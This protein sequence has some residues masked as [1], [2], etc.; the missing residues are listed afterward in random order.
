MPDDYFHT[1]IAEIVDEYDLLDELLRRPV[2][3]AG[4]RPLQDGEVLVD[5]R[6]DHGHGGKVGG[7][8][9]L[10]ASIEQDRY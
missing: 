10:V 7:V 9:L 5:E 3:D 6:D 4:D 1:C 2:D 8:L